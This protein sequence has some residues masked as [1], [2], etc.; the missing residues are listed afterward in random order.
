MERLFDCRVSN[1]A[2]LFFYRHDSPYCEIV[3]KFK[4]GRRRDLG[5]WAARLLGSYMA[6][7]GL[8]GKVQA[9]VP[10][11]LH[12][13][14][15]W[16]RGFNQAEIIARGV[17]QK[18]GGLAVAGNLLRRR[19]YTSTQTR[20]SAQSRRRNVSGAFSLNAQQAA[21]MKAS[22]INHILLV[23]DVMT[24][25]ATLKECIRLLQP[26]FTVSVAT[27]GFVE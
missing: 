12:P 19:R 26:H 8:Y 23:D 1:A 7:G 27:L 9:V 21:R 14:K 17:A 2:A 3:R 15:R 24:T 16:K 18:L 11:P 10:V 22:G 25:G 6:G 20:R 5:L 4:Y 13:L